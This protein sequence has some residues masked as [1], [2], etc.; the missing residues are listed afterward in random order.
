[1]ACSM[2]EGKEV[3]LSYVNPL[4]TF[5]TKHDKCSDCDQSVPVCE[6]SYVIEKACKYTWFCSVT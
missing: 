4:M 3:A 1:M 6:P 5:K 2:K